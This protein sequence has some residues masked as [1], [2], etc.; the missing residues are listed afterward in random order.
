ML[1]L[2]ISIL[3]KNTGLPI[4][5]IKK[6]IGDPEADVENELL[7]TEQELQVIQLLRKTI[8]YCGSI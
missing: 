6:C 4:D 5:K 2:M 7:K 8:C 3:Y 1:Y